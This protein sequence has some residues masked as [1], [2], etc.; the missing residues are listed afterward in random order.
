MAK[1]IINAPAVF[2]A[3][4]LAALFVFSAV[5]AALSE[6]PFI[7]AHKKVSLTK[8]SSGTERVSVTI[9][10]YNH[11]SET[12][13]DV[14]LTDNSWDPELFYSVSGNAS[15]SW[16]KLE[17]ASVVSHSFELE[18]GVK[19]TYYSSPALITYRVATKSKLQEAYSTP[20]LPLEILSEKVVQDKLGLAKSLMAKYGSHISVVLIVAFFANA[21][22]SPSKSSAGGGKKKH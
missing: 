13:Y 22:A 12:A 18:C 17:V 1:P 21:I 5:S 2:A 6:A 8:L 3:S 15:M 9:D 16:K 11:G 20:I 14:T 10:V 4:A 7:L 19:T